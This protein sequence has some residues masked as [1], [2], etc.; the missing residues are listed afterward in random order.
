A[1]TI[2]TV[3]AQLLYEI[4]GR[5]YANPDVVADLTSVQLE[6]L[7]EDVVGVSGTVGQPP[8]PTTKVAM[9][10]VGEWENSVWLGVTGRHFEQKRRL[11]ERSLR[12]ALGDGLAHLHVELIG[13]E[14]DDPTSQNEATGFLRV[15]ARAVTRRPSAGSSPARWWSWRWPTTPGCTRPRRRGGPNAAASIDPA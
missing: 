11:L 7:A 14:A 13:R 15:V 9:T 10:G 1:V 2:G 5:W 4:Q 6:Q 12:A 8:P 3:T